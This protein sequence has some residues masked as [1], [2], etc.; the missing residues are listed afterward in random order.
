MVQQNG[1]GYLSNYIRLKERCESG[2]DSLVTGTLREGGNSS[3]GVGVSPGDAL[4]IPDYGT[5]FLSFGVCGLPDDGRGVD[6]K[7]SLPISRK[8][9]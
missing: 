8:L 9:S 2:E 6:R 5:P 4:V 1:E 3:E 7:W